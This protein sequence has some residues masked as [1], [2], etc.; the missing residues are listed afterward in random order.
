MKD[1]RIGQKKLIEPK[2]VAYKVIKL[3]E[4][5][6]ESGSVVVMEESYD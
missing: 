3:I 4:N 5:D 6:L 1:E 2:E